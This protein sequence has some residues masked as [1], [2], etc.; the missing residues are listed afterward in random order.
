[1]RE[2]TEQSGGDK[3]GKRYVRE[4]KRVTVCGRKSLVRAGNMCQEVTKT[5][6]NP[7]SYMIQRMMEIKASSSRI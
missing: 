5:V 7:Q 6:V 2:G 1:M 3:R 4:A